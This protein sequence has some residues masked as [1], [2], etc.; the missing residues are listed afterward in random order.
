MQRRRTLRLF[1]A[2]IALNV[3]L[4][5]SR[6]ASPAHAEEANRACACRCEGDASGTSHC[7][8]DVD[9]TQCNGCEIKES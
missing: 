9:A 6:F 2:A 5:L 8:C 7:C 1:G 3:L 4:G